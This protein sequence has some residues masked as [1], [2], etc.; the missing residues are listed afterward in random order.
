MSRTASHSRVLLAIVTAIGLGLTSAPALARPARQF[1]FGIN[2]NS[3]PPG[4]VVTVSGSGWTPGSTNNEIHW[5][6]QSGPLLGTFSANNNGAFT[7]TITIPSGVTGGGHGI[8]A[9]DRCHSM[10]LIRPPR[11]AS[12]TFT[13]IL[14]PTFTPT[15]RPTPT[16]TPT[17]IPPSECDATGLAGETVITFDDDRFPVLTNL[18]GQTLVEEGVTFDEDLDAYVV[19]PVTAVPHSE[20]HALQGQIMMEF[21][22]SGRPILLT[23]NPLAEFVGVFVGLDEPAAFGEPFTAELTAWGLDEERGRYLAGTD[24]VELGP[25]V[26][27]VHHCLSVSDPHIYEVRIDYPTG[28]PELID[29]LILRR[30]ENPEAPP[31]DEE[32]PQVTITAPAE[33]SVQTSPYVRLEGE[34]IEDRELERLEVFANGVSQ[35]DIGFSYAGDTADDDKRYI[36]ALDPILGLAGCDVSVEVRA[37]DEPGNMGTDSVD[38]RLFAGDLVVTQVEPVQVVFGAP[39]VR[40]KNTAFR[41]HVTSTFGCPVDVRFRLVLDPEDWDTSLIGGFT[42][43]YGVSVP[44][45]WRFPE[46]TLPTTVPAYA[47]DL[48]VMLPVVPPGMESAVWNPD[49]NPSGLLGALR[50]VPRPI[51]S[52]V[53]FAVEIDPGNEIVETNERNNLSPVGQELTVDTRGLNVMFIPWS[54]NCTAHPGDAQSHYSW[55]LQT[56]GYTNPEAWRED[57]RDYI[58]GGR[59]ALSRALR[60]DDIARLREAAMEYSALL[61]GGFPVAEMEFGTFFNDQQLYFRENYFDFIGFDD[62]CDSTHFLEEIRS[63]VV[64]ASPQIDFVVMLLITGCCGQSPPGPDGLR[65]A[66]VDSG[67]TTGMGAEWG[68]YC[69]YPP[70]TPIPSGPTPTPW[71]FPFGGAGVDNI[72]HELS[73]NFAGAPDCYSC[74]WT[75]GGEGADCATCVTDADGFW[76]N[77]WLLIPAGTDSFMHAVCQGCVRWWRLEPILTDAGAE[78]PDGYINLVRY[79][80]APADPQALLVRGRI[81]RDGEATFFPF[82]VLENTYLDLEAGTP[83]TYAFVLKDAN[84]QELLRVGFSPRFEMMLDPQGITQPL[85]AI[86]FAYR[87]PWDPSTAEIELQDSAGNVLA[88]RAVSAHPPTVE[89]LSPSG[90][91][92]WAWGGTN[93]V[94]WRASDPDGDPLTAAIQA[95]LDG[96]ETWLPLASHIE[97]EEY[98][99]D[100][101]VFGDGQPFL[102]RVVVSDGV[103]S[104]SVSTAAALTARMGTLVTPGFRLTVVGIAAAVGVAL[105]VGG[106]LIWRRLATKPRRS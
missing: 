91:E 59:L 79:F 38:F 1:G 55:Y 12:A 76:V 6:S 93:T 40:G 22:S 96:G 7:T 39:L 80:T 63:E 97:G 2:P 20:S 30:P 4:T 103:L 58:E 25:G 49:T 105:V 17:P 74:G 100:A 36:F 52:A 86:S 21:R 64:S 57:V 82:S 44:P 92:I 71:P 14:P 45:G 73:H 69:S 87:I 35:G 41:A 78:N 29:D 15:P 32:P 101:A 27:N 5:D 42:P 50:Q 3:G 37:Y 54:F 19:D 70:P 72:L 8:W 98:R 89:L 56:A 85:E 11:W 102:L 43:D 48:Q 46:I 67:I 23:L 60:R 34:V 95:S 99:L 88:S 65:A 81:E 77:Q 47:T 61:L 33:G 106:M 66:Y 13:V 24:S 62:Y 51:G 75:P 10:I 53:E 104:A 26:E 28:D 9:C 83:G 84:N 18:Q 31:P 90:G 16:V 68:H 94:R